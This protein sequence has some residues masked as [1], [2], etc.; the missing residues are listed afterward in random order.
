MTSCL[1][2][3]ML[4]V[5][6]HYVVKDCLCLYAIGLMEAIPTRDALETV[7]GKRSFILSRSTF[8]GYGSHGGHWTGTVI[9]HC[10]QLCALEYLI[11]K[12]G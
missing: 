7:R 5:Q 4:I 11:N 3:C 9:M 1:L 12:Y 2:V 8:P 6:I 10:G